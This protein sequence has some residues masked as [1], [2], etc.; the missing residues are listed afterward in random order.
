M[1]SF[2]Q[3]INDETMMDDLRVTCESCTEESLIVTAVRVYSHCADKQEFMCNSNNVLLV[4]ESKRI[5]TFSISDKIRQNWEDARKH[6]SNL[7]YC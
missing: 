7:L 5:T 2:E 3:L 1:I 6:M 4:D